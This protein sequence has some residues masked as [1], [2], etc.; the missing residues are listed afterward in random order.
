MLRSFFQFGVG[1]FGCA[2]FIHRIRMNGVLFMSKIKR[3]SLGA[4]L[5][6]E[7]QHIFRCPICFNQMKMINSKSLVC[8]NN[9][10]F[11]LS[12]WGYLNFLSSPVKTKY[13]KKMFEA[14]RAIWKSGFF[15]PIIEKIGKRISTELKF[16][17]TNLKI[18]DA[19][20]GEGSNLSGICETINGMTE[21]N[22]LS[23]GMDISK[24][25]IYVA[26]RD[27]R[28]FIWCVGDIAKCP[29][30]KQFNVI[31][32]ILSPSN[33]SE[34]Q[35][36]LCDDGVVIKVVPNSNH[37]RELREF[38]Y[39]QTNKRTYSNIKTVN[40]FTKNLDLINFEKI[41]YSLTPDPALI[42]PLIYMTPL[43]WG[44]TVDNLQR[45]LEMNLSEITLD[46]SI[47][48]GKKKHSSP[49]S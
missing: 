45:V 24:E 22:L 4:C 13:D 34:F 17:S 28:N 46:V 20:C 33:Y 32:N 7:Y 41:Q 12:K 36:L 11:D 31:L 42:E 21:A 35:R 43:S 23:V 25:A 14:R 48:Y 15:E 16:N 1:L 49:K 5:I 37:L 30:T 38:F 40:L 26:S 29:F 8:S 39:E 27:Y 18:L 3:K 10:C 6:A 47:L 19:G 44:T 9:H 2:F